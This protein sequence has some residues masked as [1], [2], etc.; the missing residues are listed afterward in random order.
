MAAN[1]SSS[2]PPADQQTESK[3]EA[4]SPPIPSPDH[5]SSPDDGAS[6]PEEAKA[7]PEE[8][9]P[10]PR[11]VPEASRHPASTP[12]PPVAVTAPSLLEQ[13]RARHRIEEWRRIEADRDRSQRNAERMDSIN[14]EIQLVV[15]LAEREKIHWKRQQGLSTLGFGSVSIVPFSSWNPT[16]HHPAVLCLVSDRLSAIQ[17]RMETG[18]QTC[19]V[20]HQSIAASTALLQSLSAQ[21]EQ[22]QYSKIAAKEEAKKNQKK[23]P[24]SSAP[25]SSTPEPLQETGSVRQACI[26]QD[27]LLRTTSQY[28]KE[29]LTRV[30][31]S[32]EKQSEILWQ[33]MR[34]RSSEQSAKLTKAYRDQIAARQR[35]A[36]AWKAYLDATDA[37]QKHE[38]IGEPLERD[39][40][41]ACREYAQHMSQLA[42]FDTRYR[43]DTSKW[44]VPFFSSQMI[45]A[46]NPSSSYL[47]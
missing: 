15:A 44:V 36:K 6:H 16:Q 19:A 47:S 23:R 43:Q 5:Q 3:K 40:Y 17:Q 25:G 18:T 27:I 28:L 34:A 32:S 1:A 30:F 38:L 13:R 14:R 37:R 7:L 29:M 2:P 12:P 21:I 11:E 10:A 42:V 39:P 41:L 33:N 35:A 46:C 9:P 24:S 45:A 8:L 22:L 26:A 20:V 31:Q 4:S